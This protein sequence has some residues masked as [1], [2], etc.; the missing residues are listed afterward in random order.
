M[1][2]FITIESGIPRLRNESASTPIY[3]ERL[4][5]S[6]TI[7]TGTPVT[8]PNSGT[9]QGDEIQVWLNG[10]R[11]DHLVDYN[12]EGP[13]PTRTQISFTF[14]LVNGDKVDF[15]KYRGP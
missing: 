1:A 12:F 4:S 14:D 5:V 9:Y 7:S 11:L 8:L 10:L 2:K 15:R 13:G 6:S 3:D